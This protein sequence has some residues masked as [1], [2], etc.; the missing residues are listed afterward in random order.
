MHFL[1]DERRRQ[2]SVF[3]G[4]WSKTHPI[5][6]SSKIWSKSSSSRL[7]NRQKPIEVSHYLSH[8]LSCWIHF[9]LCII[10]DTWQQSRDEFECTIYNDSAAFS[11]AGSSF[12]NTN[13]KGGDHRVGLINKKR[14]DAKSFHNW[15][16]S[17][18]NGHG[19]LVYDCGVWYIHQN[20]TFIFVQKH[21][22][23]AFQRE[24]INYACKPNFGQI[25]WN[26]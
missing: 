3:A 6:R 1:I 22:T 26:L 17:H 25:G 23:S 13:G 20:H 19:F 16:I 8:Y 14:F 4:A 10:H 21:K 5:L 18:K 24:V 2:K 11:I 9:F 15:S 12:W 7:K